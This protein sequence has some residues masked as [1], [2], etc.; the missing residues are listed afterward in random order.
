MRSKPITGGAQCPERYVVYPTVWEAYTRGWRVSECVGHHQGQHLTISWPE[1]YATKE[2]AQAAV[3]SEEDRWAAR[4][5][6]PAKVVWED[7]EK[8]FCE[9]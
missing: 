5:T 3:K 9:A 1:L 2:R 7:F 8:I 6:A 4:P